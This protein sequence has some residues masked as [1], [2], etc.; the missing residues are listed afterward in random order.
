MAGAPKGAS[1]TRK[2]ELAES[3]R[4]K[5]FVRLTTRG[6]GRTLSVPMIQVEELRK[7]YQVRAKVPG[8]RLRQRTDVRALDGLS[9]SIGRGEAVGYIGPNGAG[10][11]TTI[12]I[13]S[14][15]LH[16][17]GGR[18]LVAGRVPWKD[19]KEHVRGLGVVFGQRTQLWWDLPALDSFDLLADMYGVAK[20]RYRETLGILRRELDLD[21]FI[22]TPVRQ[23]SLGQRMRCELAAALVHEPALLFLD[24]PTIG[25]DAP[26]KLALRGFVKRVNRERG[27]TV[28]LTTHDMDDVEALAGRVILIGKGKA[29]F[30]GTMASLRREAGAR[31]RILIDLAGEQAELPATPFGME[32]LERTGSRLVL[33]FDPASVSA[34]SALAAAARTYNA[35]DLSVEGAPAEELVA[36][37][38]RRHGV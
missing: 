36:A 25:L 2:F 33:S 8:R 27:V 19:R 30:D 24:E 11:S 13:L 21:A 18:C 34:A 15:I 28:I 32:L 29:L 10:K 37:L 5:R 31:K 16:P 12:K 4:S 9:F 17:D 3:S 23:L 14:G 7:T 20:N 6:R 35:A 38:Y 26:S 22:G 1:S